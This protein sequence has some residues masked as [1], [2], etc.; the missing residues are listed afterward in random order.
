MAASQYIYVMKGISRPIRAGG[1]LKDIYLSFLP[2][3]KIGVL[4]PNGCRQVDA[5]Q[6]H[7]RRG[8]RRVSG[9]GLGRRGGQVGYLAQGAR[10]RLPRRM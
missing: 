10:A 9:R 2:G 8:G 7:G 5:D 1:V 3:A 4:G 6:D